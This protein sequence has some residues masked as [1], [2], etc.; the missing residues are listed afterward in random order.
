MAEL[1]H[2][3]SFSGG[4]GSFITAK[5]VVDRYGPENTKLLFADTQIEDEDLYRFV[6]DCVKK[7]E[8]E[9]IT[10]ADGRTPW[11]VFEDVRF[12]G[13]TRVDPCSAILKRDLIKKWITSNYQPEQC[14]IHIGIDYSEKHR[15]GPVVER[16]KP[17]IYRSIMVEEGMMLSQEQ[18]ISFCEALG[19]KA[20]R[21]YK[22]GFPHNNCGGFC[23]K[24]GL[25]Q[26][27]MLFEKIPERY[28]E[29]ENSEKE[30]IERNPKSRP[31]LRKR[32]K[33]ETRY[34]TMREYRTEYLEQGKAES[35]QYD[36]GG[37]GCAIE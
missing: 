5:M 36:I 32:E 33:G 26:F 6:D 3:V 12:I 11:E 23:V 8:C 24:A 2:I 17:Y 35:D 30:A 14:E 18:K 9:L 37:C 16:Y 27:K 22:M 7:L 29:H 1:T 34:L 28:A 25:G 21:L 10:L 31:F 4:V 19:V 20:P 15:L 13:N